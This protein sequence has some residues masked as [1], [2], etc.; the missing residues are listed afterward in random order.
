MLVLIEEGNANPNVIDSNHCT[1]LHVAAVNGHLAV[2][3]VL[4]EHRADPWLGEGTG[5]TALNAA[6][7][8]RHEEVVQTLAQAM[9]RPNA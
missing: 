5:W 9:R 7:V 4:L 1:P 8:R 3:R 2:T 6:T